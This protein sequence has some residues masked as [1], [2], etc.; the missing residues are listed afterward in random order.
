MMP[1]YVL[2]VIVRQ[3]PSM[4]PGKA[5]AHSGHAASHFMYHHGRDPRVKVWAEE[6]DG[7]G[8]QINLSDTYTH[9]SNMVP[10]KLLFDFDKSAERARGMGYIAGIVVDP[11]YPFHV[12]KEHS[13]YMV[14]SSSVRLVAEGPTHDTYV[15][16]EA[17]AMYI[18]GPKDC[19]KLQSLVG[20]LELKR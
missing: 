18:F 8:T 3:F 5:E 15:R 14:A 9:P 16:R 20:V 2:Y 19:P 1:Q 11:E 12:T 10:G 6:A 4:N 7:F 17:T 13:K